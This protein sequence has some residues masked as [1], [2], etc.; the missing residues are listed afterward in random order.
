MLHDAETSARMYVGI[1]KLIKRCFCEALV[2]ITYSFL[3]ITWNFKTSLMILILTWRTPQMF[4]NKLLPWIMGDVLQALNIFER[5]THLKQTNYCQLPKCLY[6]II[7]KCIC[8][9]YRTSAVQHS[10]NPNPDRTGPKSRECNR[11][12]F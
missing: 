5:R 8:K 3:Q 2:V 1:I 9:L 11:N 4:A 7:W 10:T 6:Q 12:Y